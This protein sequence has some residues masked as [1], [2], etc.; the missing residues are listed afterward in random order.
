MALDATVKGASA[1]A[2]MT[3][4]T[5]DAYFDDHPGR[6]SWYA[7]GTK[8]RDRAII[9]ATRLL[10]V[11]A[12]SGAKRTTAQALAWPRAGLVTRDGE[13]ID[14]DTIPAQVERMTA[15][16]A[17]A[18]LVRTVQV[19]PVGLESFDTEDAGGNPPPEQDIKPS[20]LGEIPGYIL[21]F[22]RE[23]EQARGSSVPVVRT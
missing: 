7:A 16:L 6:S 19:V 5:A 18:L 11:R 9:H 21:R 3:R 22:G 13:S 14:E 8:D 2:Y 4:A 1:N 15:E 10:E 17:L 23:L 12:F 20:A